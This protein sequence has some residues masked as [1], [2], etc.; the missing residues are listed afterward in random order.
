L[1]YVLHH[2]SVFRVSPAA[3]LG[4]DAKSLSDDQ[5]VYMNDHLRILSGLYG[6]LKP[7]D[8]IQPY[9]LDFGK[10][11]ATDGGKLTASCVDHMF[12]SFNWINLLC[13]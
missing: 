9:R 1:S 3:Y 8:L 2:V 11:L 4:L 12:L 5:L 13:R 10:K 7:L 6:T